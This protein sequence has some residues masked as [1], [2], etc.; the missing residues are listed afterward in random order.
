MSPSAIQSR[1]SDRWS[2]P[3]AVFQDEIYRCL[4]R[5]LHHLPILSEYSHSRRGSS[6]RVDFYVFDKG[7]GI[8]ILQSGSKAQITEH[9]ARFGPGGK[10]GRWNILRDYMVLNF[11]PKSKLRTL[12]L[13]GKLHSFHSTSLFD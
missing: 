1:S 7:W 6:G 9:A 2:I 5:E 12:K 13:A 10:Y 3:E 4:H 11:C 8:E